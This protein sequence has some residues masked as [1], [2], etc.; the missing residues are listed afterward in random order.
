[1]TEGI[2]RVCSLENHL[3][4]LGDRLRRKGG[5]HGEELKEEA[6]ERASLEEAFASLPATEQPSAAAAPQSELHVA[7]GYRRFSWQRAALR[8]ESA[9]V[10]AANNLM[11]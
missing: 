4:H 1:M 6:A 2:R 5:P 3:G 7:P 9:L 8:I 11:E 10:E